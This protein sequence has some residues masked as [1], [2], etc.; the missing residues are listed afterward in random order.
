[1]C[2]AERLAE[3]PERRWP[4]PWVGVV[5]PKCDDNARLNPRLVP[6]ADVSEAPPPPRPGRPR[7][8]GQNQN[9]CALT[10]VP[11]V[12]GSSAAATVIC[13]REFGEI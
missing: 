6:C 1:M 2:D 10:G 11:G 13:G 5:D 3:A 9:S 4:V 7:K 12:T 8:V